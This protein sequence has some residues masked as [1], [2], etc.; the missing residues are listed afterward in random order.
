MDENKI[1]DLMNNIDYGWV[2]KNNKK[3]IYDYDTY[4]NEYKLQSPEEIIN[5]R[6]GVCW[7]QVELERYYFDKINIP[8][9]TF[10]IVHYDDNKCPTHTFLV[11]EK[12][13][14]YYWFEHSWEKFRGIH[15]YSTLNELL[16]DIKNKFI[17]YELNNQYDNNNLKIYEYSKPKYNI[18][19]QEFY[20]HCENGILINII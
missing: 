18:S 10:F 17:Q 16:N 5:N 20:S 6:I 1:M 14:N 4:S 15:A 7:D 19:T 2:D 11:Y 12:D 9:K 13:N 3:H 8:I